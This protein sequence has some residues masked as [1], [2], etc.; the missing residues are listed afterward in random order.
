MQLAEETMLQ[1]L[2]MTWFEWQTTTV[3]ECWFFPLSAV[4]VLK[5]SL[6]EIYIS[7]QLKQQEYII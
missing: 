2:L 5:L 7:L 1:K 3:R 4:D 6:E